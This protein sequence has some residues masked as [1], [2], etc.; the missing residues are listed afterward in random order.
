MISLHEKKVPKLLKK[1]YMIVLNANSVKNY[2]YQ[3]KI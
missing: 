1:L 3:S 2:K